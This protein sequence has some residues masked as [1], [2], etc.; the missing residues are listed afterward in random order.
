MRTINVYEAKTHLSRLLAAVASGEEII[1][2]RAGKPLAKL[3]PYQEAEQPREPG[4][5]R[6][7]VRI[8]SD[9]DALPESLA[10]AFRGEAP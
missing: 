8:A 7:R 2:T 4:Y 10:A 5:W 1:I 6:G 3:I 9:F